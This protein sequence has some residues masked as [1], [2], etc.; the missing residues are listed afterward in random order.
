MK[1]T[2]FIFC[3][4]S[5]TVFS[6]KNVFEFSLAGV[7]DKNLNVSVPGVF[8]FES[9]PSIDNRY[10]AGLAFA[11]ERKSFSHVSFFFG[12]RD[13]VRKIDYIYNNSV[14]GGFIQNTLEVPV[15]VRYTKAINEQYKFRMDLSPGFNYVL[16]KDASTIQ[17][18][19]PTGET[20]LQFEKNKKLSYFAQVSVGLESKISE[21]SA[22]V[23]FFAYQY[24]I[25]SLCG[26]TINSPWIDRSATPVYTDYFSAGLAYRFF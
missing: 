3:F 16:T 12:L 2:F 19:D 26:L 1:N 17:M 13:V 10:A 11:Y 21:K 20:S 15:G 24:Q 22:L 4:Y 6:Q 9:I 18:G 25:T 8:S 14:T 23:F 7:I 5:L